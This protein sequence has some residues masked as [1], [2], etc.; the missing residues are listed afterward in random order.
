MTEIK[1]IEIKEIKIEQNKIDDLSSSLDRI[2]ENV[3][4]D[5]I[6]RKNIALSKGSMVNDFDKWKKEQKVV[7]NQFKKEIA[8]STKTIQ[9]IVNSSINNLM[10]QLK[11]LGEDISKIKIE[12][13][14]KTNIVK[15]ANKAVKLL[16]QNVFNDYQKSVAKIYRLKNTDK[17][18][19]AIY[20][21]T[22]NGIDEGVGIVYRDGR[23]VSFKSYMEMN[24][25]TTVRQ[26]ANQY[27]F[28]ASKS[29]GVVFYIADFYGD[30]AKDHVDYQGKYYY[31]E[32]WQ[33]FGYDEETSNNIQNFIDSY[34]MQSYQ[35]VVDNAPF[36]TTRPNCRHS[37]R[38]V[39]LE[40]ALKY[41][42]KKMTENYGIRKGTYNDDNYK[43]LQEQ[44]KNERMIRFY[45]TR[46]EEHQQM[47]KQMNNP[48][49]KAKIKK[50]KE[51]IKKWNERQEDL[52]LH[53]E[54]LKRDKRRENNKILVNDLGAGYHLGLKIDGKNMYFKKEK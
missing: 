46:L 17:L 21:Q 48:D 29:N 10:L 31:D 34:G 35:S 18:Y 50:D 40:D 30:C 41:T 33:S 16:G 13:I 28:Q 15:Q 22:K 52:L 39:V 47:N 20:E 54:H 43:A 27:L 53:N 51:L 14:G 44:R 42:D 6:V 45:K 7:K 9:T 2:F 38:P 11:N 23:K 1:K 5:M 32:D 25:R 3:E 19:D 8:N 37:L 12:Q 4:N 49:L 36:L 24:V 26:E